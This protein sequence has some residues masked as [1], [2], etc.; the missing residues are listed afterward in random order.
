MCLIVALGDTSK[1]PFCDHRQ[2]TKDDK[3]RRLSLC[4][5]DLSVG[6][7]RYYVRGHIYDGLGLK[8]VSSQ[9]TF[10]GLYVGILTS[11]FRKKRR[12]EHKT[13]CTEQPNNVKIIDVFRCCIWCVTPSWWVSPSSPTCSVRVTPR[14]PST[15][16][17]TRRRASASPLSAE[18]LRYDLN[19]SITLCS[20]IWRVK[21]THFLGV[22]RFRASR[23]CN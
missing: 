14:W 21:F 15:S 11:P 1:F 16:S 22:M 6:S 13:H 2:T 12:K 4:D 20:H 8:Y 17:R 10:C 23:N 9:M 18:T 19:N 7:R 5:P 3:H